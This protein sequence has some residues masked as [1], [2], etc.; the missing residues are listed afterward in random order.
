[1]THRH[2]LTATAALLV[3]AT[4]VHAQARGDQGRGDQHPPAKQISPKEQQQRIQEQQKRETDYKSKLTQQVSDAQKHAAEL[5]MQKRPAQYNVHQTYLQNL[6]QQQV[7]LQTPRDYAH[8]PAFKA[9]L[10]FRYNY[11]GAYHQ[12]T[13]YG[14]DM[15][16]A[17]VNAGYERGVQ[18]GIADRTDHA[19]SNYQITYGYRDANYGYNGSYVDQSDYNYYFRQGFQRGYEDGYASRYQYGTY[20]N[21]TASILGSLLTSILGF[22]PIP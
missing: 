12:T 10:A 15:L 4:A 8:D 22:Q 13:Q 9:P 20:N 5:Q 1:M 16:R 2:V 21:G 19:P 11:G 17:A 18:A 7:K 14:A 6:Q 3:C